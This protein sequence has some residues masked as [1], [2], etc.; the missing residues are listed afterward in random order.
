MALTT[1]TASFETAQ[2]TLEVKY[3]LDSQYNKCYYLNEYCER[4]LQLNVQNW[5]WAMKQKPGENLNLK[6][7]LALDLWDTS[8]VF[9]Q[10]D[11]W[12]SWLIVGMY[13][14]PESSQPRTGHF[15]SSYYTH[16]SWK[17]CPQVHV[18][19]FKHLT[20]RHLNSFVTRGVGVVVEVFKL[21][22]T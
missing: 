20:V 14:V 18:E 4:P 10:F 6:G 8:A 19:P 5:S 21:I 7:I 12:L 17:I 3:L 11:F 15:V 13:S 16:C 22:H 2:T 1:I 9:Y